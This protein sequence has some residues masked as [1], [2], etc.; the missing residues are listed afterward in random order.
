VTRVGGADG[1]LPEKLRI[2]DGVRSLA[3]DRVRV[4]RGRTDPRV[5]GRGV[6]PDKL[7]VRPLSNLAG[8]VAQEPERAGGER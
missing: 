7:R 5:L 1:A 4:E 2:E 8:E 6:P 3:I